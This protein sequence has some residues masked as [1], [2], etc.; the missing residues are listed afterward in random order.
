MSAISRFRARLISF[1]LDAS[2]G[3]QMVHIED[4][5]LS[6]SG[7]KIA[8][9][10]ST[11]EYLGQGGDIEACE[12]LR[13][14]LIMPGFIDTHLHAPQY[15]IMG[16]FG[17]RL[18]DW[19][20]KYAFP[21]EL[22]FA[23]AQYAAAEAEH[24]VNTMLANGTTSSQLFTTTHAHTCDALF[25]AAAKR[26]LCL[27]AGKLMMDQNAPSGLLS[28]AEVC[29]RETQTL[30]DRWHH[31]GR[32]A[33]ALT[34]RFAITS[35]ERQL[36]YCR[37][38][39][40]ANPTVLVQTH[41]SENPE[42]LAEVSR[43]FPGAKDYLDVYESYNLLGPSSTFAHCIHLSDGERSRLFDSQSKVAFCPS[44]NLFLGSGLLDVAEIPW[45]NFSVASDVGGG[46]SL[47][48]LTTCAEA[49]KVCQLKNRT[50]HP[51]E[52]LYAATAGNAKALSLEQEVG[53]LKEGFW[54][55]FIVVDAEHDI[56]LRKT[57]WGLEHLEGALFSLI[58]FGGRQ[59]ILRTYV[60]GELVHGGA[61]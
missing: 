30:I 10:Q 42:E 50:L 27:I 35:S 29:A 54:A 8:G 5:V 61:S 15:R 36:D 3:V 38:L 7:S 19:L 57:N 14:A 28:A 2:D 13:P 6:L 58:M 56:A 24:F 49:Y 16:A 4:G 43:L 39:R 22:A 37:G 31:R 55:D 60:A 25:A 59:N 33:Y 12:D 45:D 26:N 23:D 47:S 17:T 46:T 52:L 34:P 40:Q 21:A 44:S 51:Y 18:L 11:A 41:L 48:M 9:V 53:Q 32:A 20:E 1:E